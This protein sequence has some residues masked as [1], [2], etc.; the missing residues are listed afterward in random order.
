MEVKENNSSAG[1]WPSTYSLQ[2]KA[3]DGLYR[4]TTITFKFSFFPNGNVVILRFFKD[5]WYLWGKN[6]EN[7]QLLDIL[8]FL[9]SDKKPFILKP[10]NEAKPARGS[11]F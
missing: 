9:K 6:S 2:Q 3:D 1:E 8:V 10:N 11:V 7:M 5:T 4:L